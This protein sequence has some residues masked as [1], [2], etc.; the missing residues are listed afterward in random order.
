MN[1][2]QLLQRTALVHGDRPAVL[3]AARPQ[4]GEAEWRARVDLAAAYR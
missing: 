3:A 4:F 2:A 1:I